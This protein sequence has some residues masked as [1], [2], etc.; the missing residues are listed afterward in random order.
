M[1]LRRLMIFLITISLISCSSV[2]VAQ[3]AP[4]PTGDCAEA[5]QKFNQCREL[6]VECNKQLKNEYA[7]LDKVNRE[8]Q[9]EKF[10]AGLKGFA[11]GAGTVA[12]IGLIAVTVSSIK[13]K[14]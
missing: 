13:T 9:R 2:P 4:V 12:V 11:I 7:F 1:R 3:P 5:K 14:K 10:F 8:M 6:L